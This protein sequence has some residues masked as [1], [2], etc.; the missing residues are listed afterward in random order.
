MCTKALRELAIVHNG[1]QGIGSCAH[2][3][4]IM[5]QSVCTNLLQQWAIVHT[6]QLCY[7]QCAQWCS[8]DMHLCTLPANCAMSSVHKSMQGIGSC[9]H[10]QPIMQQSVCTNLLQQW[11]I[12]HTTCSTIGWQCAQSH[13]SNKL[14]C[15]LLANCILR[16]VHI[17]IWGCS[18]VHTTS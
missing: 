10:H 16:G 12:V 11:A 4:P 17:A 5:Q 8:E 15:T 14:L 7:E 18:Y 3:Q 13:S 6:S 2:C 9:A 1:V